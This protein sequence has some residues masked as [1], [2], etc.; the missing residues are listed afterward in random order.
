VL[1]TGKIMSLSQK[2][3]GFVPKLSVSVAGMTLCLMG[4]LVLAEV[5]ARNLFNYGFPFA[6]EYS[7]YAVPI[8]G[9]VGAAYAL[10]NG[11]HVK[12]DLVLTKI[13]YGPRQIVILTGYIF[14]LG[15]MLLLAQQSFIMA[16]SNIETKALALYPTLTPLGYPQLVMG[17][18]FALFSVQLVIEITRMTKKIINERNTE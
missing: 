1:F 17:T 16:F 6:V 18:G 8:I 5:I 12:A 10:N 15:L 9:L 11:D 4:G 14:G 2:I 7:E 13:P 3:A